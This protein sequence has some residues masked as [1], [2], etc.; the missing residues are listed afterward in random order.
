MKHLRTD[1]IKETWTNENIK[2]SSPATPESIKV[3]EEIIG[4]Q[5]PDDFKEF[6]L[7]LDGFVD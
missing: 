7:Q 3:A 1:K 5:F 6:Y 4:F 2:L